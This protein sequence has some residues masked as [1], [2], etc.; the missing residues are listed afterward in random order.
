MRQWDTKRQFKPRYGAVFR[1][2]L[3]AWVK[4]SANLAKSV[5]LSLHCIAD[6]AL[7]LLLLI[8]SP[9]MLPVFL[10]AEKRLTRRRRLDY[11]IAQRLADKDI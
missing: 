5:S 4:P 6:L 8:L 1:G 7:G 3:L 9:V 2:F 10:I 11:L